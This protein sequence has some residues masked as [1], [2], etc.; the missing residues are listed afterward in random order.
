MENAVRRLSII[1]VLVLTLLFVPSEFDGIMSSVAYVLAFV[2]PFLLGIIW[3]RSEEKSE[4]EEPEPSY[5]TIDKNGLLITLLTLIPC[6]FIT[7][8][9]SYLTN[10]VMNFFDLQSSVYIGN[11]LFFALLMQAA[12]PAVLE[13]LVFRYLPLRFIGKRAVLPCIIL[14]SLFFSL[15]HHSFFS[16]IYTFFAGVIFITLDLAVGSVIPSMIIHFVNNCLSVLW[17]FYS[18]N[19]G[20]ALPFF[21]ALSALTV[22]S[23]LGIFLAR[24]RFCAS[25]STLRTEGERYEHNASPLFILIPSLAV[26]ILELL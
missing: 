22:L 10:L 5:I 18:G 3:L 21:L 20:F 9:L 26:A 4:R 19:S 2:L 15:V 11:D 12:I 6:V 14:S 25:L 8:S 13:E 17:I 16:Y 23:C 7:F 24:E 1:S